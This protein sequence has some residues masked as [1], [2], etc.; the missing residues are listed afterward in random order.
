MHPKVAYICEVLHITPSVDPISWCQ[1]MCVCVEEMFGFDVWDSPGDDHPLPDVPSKALR[2]HKTMHKMPHLMLS[3]KAGS[4]KDT[5]ADYLA[6]VHGYC[7]LRFAGP[8][9]RV[10]AA[11]TGTTFAMNMEAKS[12]IASGFA[13]SLGKMQ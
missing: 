11:I 6:P 3:G 8:I 12:H 10:V 13:H 7:V 5:A 1:R 9:K 4:G 2:T